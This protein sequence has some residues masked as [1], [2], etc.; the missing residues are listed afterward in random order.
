MAFT[1]AGSS[2][3]TLVAVYTGAGVD[4][5]NTITTN[6]DAVGNGGY[7]GFSFVTFDATAGQEYSIAVD[8]YAL[9][10]GS[11]VLS[12]AKIPENDKFAD[13]QVITRSSGSVAGNNLGA[14]AEPGEPNHSGCEPSRSV[15]YV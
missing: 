11:V 2:F 7:G 15:W 14:S 10:S 9:G 3:D 5:L 12:W 1:T 6:D 4:G 13:A 8:G